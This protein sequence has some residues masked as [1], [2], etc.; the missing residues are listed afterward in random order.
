MFFLLSAKYTIQTKN[1][2]TPQAYVG[3]IVFLFIILLLGWSTVLFGFVAGTVAGVIGVKLYDSEILENLATAG[4][5]E[6]ELTITGVYASHPIV[7]MD[8][9]KK[10]QISNNPDIPREK[11]VPEYPVKVTIPCYDRSNIHGA[12]LD[13]ILTRKSTSDK[14]MLIAKGSLKQK[15]FLELSPKYTKR[16]ENQSIIGVGALKIKEIDEKQDKSQATEKHTRLL[17]LLAPLLNKVWCGKSPKGVAFLGASKHSSTV[18]DQGPIAL[19]SH[20]GSRMHTMAGADFLQS[21]D[22]NRG[23]VDITYDDEVIS[24]PVI[25]KHKPSRSD[26]S[27]MPF[28]QKI[29]EMAENNKLLIV[30]QDYITGAISRGDVLPKNV[31][32]IGQALRDEP[33]KKMY[34]H[35]FVNPKAYDSLLRLLGNL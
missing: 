18:P 23:I 12:P 29:E 16:D 6:S 19:I 5:A 34:L 31:I 14:N 10:L 22:M 21:K 13:M 33:G 9:S 35:T 8:G 1:I 15:Y 28:L 3:I 11:N 30:V 2:M 25:E 24:L 32:Y 7:L 27:Q 20:V 26:I 17:E 4:G